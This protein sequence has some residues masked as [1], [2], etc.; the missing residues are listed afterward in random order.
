MSRG[1]PQA[2]NSAQHKS[3]NFI[4]K[5]LL[6]ILPIPKLHHF[7]TGHLALNAIFGQWFS[8]SCELKEQNHKPVYEKTIASAIT[9]ITQ[10]GGIVCKKDFAVRCNS[11]QQKLQ[12]MSLKLYIIHAIYRIYFNLALFPRMWMR[13]IKGSTGA[14]TTVKIWRCLSRDWKLKLQ[15]RWQIT[16]D[17]EI[18]SV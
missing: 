9:S 5:F 12:A 2:M 15:A 16:L 7:Q 4:Q 10:W 17:P 14:E 1:I 13:Q 3:G 8:L 11:H 18:S 6:H